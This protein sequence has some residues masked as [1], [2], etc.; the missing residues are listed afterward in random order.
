MNNYAIQGHIKVKKP[1]IDICQVR[2]PPSIFAHL[3][4]RIRWISFRGLE[5][6]LIRYPD[7]Y[8][9]AGMIKTNSQRKQ[10]FHLGGNKWCEIVRIVMWCEKTLEENRSNPFIVV[11]QHQNKLL[12]RCLRGC[13]RAPPPTSSGWCTPC[14]CRGRRSTAGQTAPAAERAEASR[15]AIQ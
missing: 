6:T 11:S 10:I 12:R 3:S 7:A 5:N 15:G 1:K 14:P 8:E 9:T 2:F 13:S 4:V